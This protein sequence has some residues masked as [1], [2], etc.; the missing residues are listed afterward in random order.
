MFSKTS[1]AV[2]SPNVQSSI[3]KVRLA[4]ILFFLAV[5]QGRKKIT[6]REVLSV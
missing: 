2:S 3:A 4:L 5:Q 6:V 1:D